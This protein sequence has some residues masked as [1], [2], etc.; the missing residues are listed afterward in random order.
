M[1]IFESASS[2]HKW[3]DRLKSDRSVIENTWQEISDHALGSRDFTTDRTPGQTRT[4]AIYDATCLDAHQLLAGG[5]H[6]LLTNPATEWFDLEPTNPLLNEDYD[7]AAWLEDARHK[8][9]VVTQGAASAFQQQIAEYWLDVTGWGMGGLSLTRQGKDEIVFKAHPL[10]ELYVED[11]DDGKIDVTFRESTLT[12]RQFAARFQD[13][14]VPEIQKALE[15]NNPEQRFKV[16]HL[17]AKSDDPYAAEGSPFS[18]EWTG[19]FCYLGGKSDMILETHGYDENPIMVGRWSVETG[20]VYGRGPGHLALPEAKMLNEMAKTKLKALQKAA[21]PPLLVQNESILNGIRT[22]PG[23]VNIVE[24]QFGMGGSAEAI[25]PLQNGARVDLT[26]EEITSRQQLVRRLFFANV[27]QLFD[28]P[29]MTAEQVIQLSHRMQQLMAPNIG[30]QQ[31]E[32]L[33]PILNRLF[34]IMLR[35]KMFSPI[36]TGLQ[37][38]DIRVTYVSPIIRAQRVSDARS[39]LE[40]WQSAALIAQSTQS[41]DVFD[42]LDADN[43]LRVIHSANGAPRSILMDV[44]AVEAIREGRQ[45]AQ[46]QQAEMAQMSQA[47]EAIGKAGPGMQAL[48]EAAPGGGPGGPAE[49]AA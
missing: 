1:S 14:E 29:N 40:T 6:G 43:S 32:M 13:A 37:G 41:P 34:G 7:N 36:P 27:L 21:D 12:A 4:E 33:E 38:Q 3:L 48:S 45:Q 5:M 28:D 23:G 47:A 20:E 18:K 42:I 44:D 46:Q 9:L 25:R 16:V 49:V 10:Q 26:Q 31:S 15:K 22:H 2:I 8:M 19:V 24:P 17:I 35:A 39:V 11:D 30:R